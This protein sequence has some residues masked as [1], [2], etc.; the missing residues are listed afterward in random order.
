M[1]QALSLN[2]LDNQHEEEE[3]EDFSALDEP[4]PECTLA[5][6]HGVGKQVNESNKGCLLGI[7]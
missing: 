3:E 2:R 1:W 7:C 4:L 6:T 5:F